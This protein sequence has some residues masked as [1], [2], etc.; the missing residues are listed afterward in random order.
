MHLLV[1]LWFIMNVLPENLIVFLNMKM[2][3]VLT[4]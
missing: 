2:P 4:T 3:I 1:F